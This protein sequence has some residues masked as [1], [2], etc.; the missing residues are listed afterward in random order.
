MKTLSEN[1]SAKNDWPF[2]DGLRAVKWKKSCKNSSLNSFDI[3]QLTCEN[4]ELLK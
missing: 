2:W 1:Q 3:F 4:I